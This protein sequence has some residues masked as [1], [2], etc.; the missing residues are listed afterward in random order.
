M[1]ILK[2]VGFEH[3]N[4]LSHE[5]V[6]INIIDNTAADNY[7]GVDDMCVFERNITKILDLYGEPKGDLLRY[8]VREYINKDTT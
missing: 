3:R 1:S 5:L 6:I 2:Q 7:N 8:N 4:W